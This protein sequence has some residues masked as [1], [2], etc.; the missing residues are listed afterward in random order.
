MGNYSAGEIRYLVPCPPESRRHQPA[1]PTSSFPWSEAA[2]AA[3]NA[4]FS[5]SSRRRHRR[6]HATTPCRIVPSRPPA[7]RRH[8]PFRP[9]SRGPRYRGTAAFL[10]SEIVCRPARDAATVLRAPVV[11]NGRNALRRARAH[12]L[13]A[14][15]QL[16]TALRASPGSGTAEK[17]PPRTAR[18]VEHLQRQPRIG[19]APQS[20]A[21]AGARNPLLVLG[22]MGASAPKPLTARRVAATARAR[23]RPATLGDYRACRAGVRR[24]APALPHRRPEQAVAEALVPRADA[25]KGLALHG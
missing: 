20:R 18:A 8:R 7:G 14:A 24:R 23:H 17:K 15:A 6:D 22:D 5:R 2:V 3:Q 9:R 1:P 13:A 16:A 4:K 10:E 21:R 12:A 11:H 19:G 25:G